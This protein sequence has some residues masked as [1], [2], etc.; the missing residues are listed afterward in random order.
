VRGWKSE[1]ARHSL[2]ARGVKT[3]NRLFGRK[4]LYQK[5]KTAVAMSKKDKLE[6]SFTADWDG[7]EFKVIDGKANPFTNEL[8]DEEREASFHVHPSN[9]SPLPSPFDVVNAERNEEIWSAVG[10][11]EGEVFIF[12]PNNSTEE[13]KEFDRL[14]WD[15]WLQFQG[16]DDNGGTHFDGDGG[17]KLSKANRLLD[18]DIASGRGKIVKVLWRGKL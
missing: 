2:A 3:G 7:D 6:H 4:D 11:L 10:N 18:D 15:A 8:P 16:H 1:P 14:T 9:E 5:A 12:E 17:E 13:Y